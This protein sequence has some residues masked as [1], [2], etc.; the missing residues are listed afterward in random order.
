[1]HALGWRCQV[2][3]SHMKNRA[4]G[5]ISAGDKEDAQFARKLASTHFP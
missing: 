4:A 3:C 1:M 5:I 2:V